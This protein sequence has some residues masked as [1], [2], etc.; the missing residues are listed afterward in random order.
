M[1]AT[2]FAEYKFPNSDVEPHIFTPIHQWVKSQKHRWFV[3]SN[4][5]SKEELDT[6]R[7]MTN[8][9]TNTVDAA[10]ENLSSSKVYNNHDDNISELRRIAKGHR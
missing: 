7:T 6:N 10:A 4:Q 8:N 2:L 1:N 9:A 5:Q 3:E